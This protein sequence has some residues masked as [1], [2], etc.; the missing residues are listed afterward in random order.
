[1]STKSTVAYGSNFHFYKEALDE[2]FIYLELEGVQ[3]EASYNR[4][5][6]PIPVHIWEVI[7]RYPGIDLS[8]AEK[9][10]EEIVQYVERAVDERIREYQ[11]ADERSKKLIAFF[12]SL[13]FGGADISRSEQIETGIAYFQRTREHQQQVKRAIEE[14]ERDNSRSS[15]GGNPPDL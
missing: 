5:T 4:V 7:R 1:M 13:V 2:S 12:G 15:R 9:S 14:L 8:W 10:D 11:E 3:F 6:V